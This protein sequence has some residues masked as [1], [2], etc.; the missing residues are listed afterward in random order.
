MRFLKRKTVPGSV[1]SE[2]SS[3]ST[4]EEVLTLEF[5][6]PEREV[7]TLEFA[8]PERFARSFVSQSL[9]LT[10]RRFAHIAFRGGSRDLGQD[11]PRWPDFA[12]PPC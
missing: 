11:R 5:A 12:A 2:T 7:L 3:T 6:G 8:G 4:N 1:T 10:P 9:P